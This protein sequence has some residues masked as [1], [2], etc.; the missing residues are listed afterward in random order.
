M[1]IIEKITMILLSVAIV[2]TS[3]TNVNQNRRIQN[4]EKQVQVLQED[5]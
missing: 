2:I 1:T 3:L 4:L 5:Q